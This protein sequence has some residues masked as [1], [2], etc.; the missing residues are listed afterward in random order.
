VG[1]QV[2]GPIIFLHSRRDLQQ[3]S[4]VPVTDSESIG[5]AGPRERAILTRVFGRSISVTSAN[6]QGRL[7]AHSEQGQREYAVQVSCISVPDTSV[8]FLD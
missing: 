1:Q 6:P 8:Q 3:F 2:W 4:D 7:Q 5:R